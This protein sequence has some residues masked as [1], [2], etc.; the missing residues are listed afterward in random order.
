LKYAREEQTYLGFNSGLRQGDALSTVLFNLVLEAALLKIDL[1][2][3]ISTRTKQLCAYADDVI[4]ARTQKALNETFITLQK[5]AEKMG[6]IINTNKIK[7][8]QVTRKT[9][10]IK[11]DIEVAGKS[12]KVVNQFI[13]LGSQINSKNLI[14]E[15]IRLRIEA[16]KRNLFANTKLFENKDFNAASKLQIHKSIIRPVVTYGCVTWA[17]TVTEKNRLLIFERRVL[18]KI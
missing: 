4:L 11:Q 1:R 15:E 5:E 3:N 8:L 10:T 16:G 2:G 13:Y 14:K 9:N 7:Y 6:L 12:Y 17:M 18:K